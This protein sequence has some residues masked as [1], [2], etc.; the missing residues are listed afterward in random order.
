MK[1]AAFALAG[2]LLLAGCPIPQPLPDYPPG[3]ITPPRIVMDDS[4]SQ[5]AYPETVVLVPEGCP[6]TAAP[7]FPLSA[8][9]V[10]VNT[11]EQV[12]ARWFVNY[13]PM[14][15]ARN[16][17]RQED[18]IHGVNTTPLQT[19][20]T[21]PMFTFHPY[22]SY[23]TVGSTGSGDGRN[24]GAVE[25]VELVVSNGFD[26]AG[27]PPGS[28]APLPFRSPAPGFETQMFRWVFVTVQSPT[29]TCPSP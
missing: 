27:D 3:T 20:R 26:P 8:A 25:I 12:S 21:V 23:G 17:P 14:D 4:I 15:P 28:A 18:E 24:L 1:R 16:A 5:I 19:R 22:G 13:D 29:V 9:L 7:S 11:I 6:T 10:D 2:A